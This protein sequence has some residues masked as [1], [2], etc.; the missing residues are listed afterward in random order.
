MMEKYSQGGRPL[1]SVG[2]ITCIFNTV[3][4]QYFNNSF[5]TMFSLLTYGSE[6]ILETIR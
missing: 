2:S 1:I 3:Y 5:Q 4:L 6:Y